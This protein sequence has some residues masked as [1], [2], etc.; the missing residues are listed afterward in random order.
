[1]VVG[2]TCA[3]SAYITTNVV[4]S[5]PELCNKVCQWVTTG[6]RFS[7]G[8]WYNWN[9]VESGVKQNNSNPCDR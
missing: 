7:Q 8:P 3:I 1:M 6:R 2:F 4:S 5:N 9:I